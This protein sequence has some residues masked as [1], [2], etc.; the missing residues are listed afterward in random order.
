MKASL[1]RMSAPLVAA[2]MALLTH[3]PGTA[4]GFSYSGSYINDWSSCDTSCKGASSLNYT[5][6]Q[7]NGFD[8][9]MASLGHTRMHKFS[10]TSVWASDYIEDV[11]G[12]QDHLYS[13]DSD[14]VV[15]S[16]H[17]SAPTSSSG[18]VFRAPMCR[19]GS[20]SSCMYDSPNSRFGE[21]SGA[22]ATPYSGNTRWLMWLTCYSVDTAPH[23]QWGAAFWQGLEYVMGFRGISTDSAN[24]DEVPA[25]WVG[26]A[27]SSSQSFK[28]AWFWAI[29]DWW[30]N[31]TGAV[32]STG[33]DAASAEYRRDN[34]N[35]NSSRRAPEDYGY[36]V[37][38]SWHEG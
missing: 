27:I 34:L 7:I 3:L 1:L 8:S 21:R 28:A 37:S 6:D 15:Y 36:W 22:Y 31:D 32:A 26:E 25:D 20:S 29:E 2:S 24:T 9:A 10:N 38:W 16:G 11:L 23:Q 17:G 18:Q 14:I 4:H 19:Q 35:K 13:D 33:P 5:D 30:V 12:G